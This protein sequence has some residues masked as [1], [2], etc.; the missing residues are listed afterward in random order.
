MTAMSFSA[1]LEAN[2]G[3][4]Y[5]VFAPPTVEQLGLEREQA[6]EQF[7]AAW[8][9]RARARAEL[10]EAEAELRAAVRDCKGVGARVQQLA[11]LAQVTRPTIYAWLRGCRA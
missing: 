3:E 10:A 6:R 11:V 2:R 5:G 8:E 7:A 9:R 4:A 1:F